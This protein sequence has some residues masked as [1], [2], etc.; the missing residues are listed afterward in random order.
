MNERKIVS[1][2]LQPSYELQPAFTYQG[3]KFRPIRYVADFK[4][5]DWDNHTF[6][7]DIKGSRGFLTDVFKLKM[8]MLLYKYPDIDFRIVTMK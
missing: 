3:K 6:V 5:T 4:V 1:F 8:K 2:E 7:V